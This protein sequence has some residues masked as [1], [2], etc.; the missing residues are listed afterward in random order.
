MKLKN[1]SEILFEILI[2]YSPAWLLEIFENSIV[3]L[4][5]TLEII[6][7]LN[8]RA[9]P[10]GLGLASTV[11]GIEKLFT[12]SIMKELLFTLIIGASKI[13]VLYKAYKLH[14]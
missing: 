3:E 6:T 5:K 10:S 9:Y 14:R 11:N 1:A 2:E 7:F 12:S 13:K 4:I 8:N